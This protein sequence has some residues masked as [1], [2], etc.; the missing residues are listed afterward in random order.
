MIYFDAAEKVALTTENNQIIVWTEKGD[1]TPR[2]F[3]S[4]KGYKVLL[5]GDNG[6]WWE[7]K[8]IECKNCYYAQLWLGDFPFG[9]WCWAIKK[10][11]TTKRVWVREIETDINPRGLS[12]S[13]QWIQ[14]CEEYEPVT[15]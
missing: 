9:S 6:A 13:Q 1:G 10:C 2:I 15:A 12:T 5:K 14:C 3:T 11:K 4:E 7:Q 8:K